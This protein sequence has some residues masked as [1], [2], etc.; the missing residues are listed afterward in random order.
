MV[1][2]DVKDSFMCYAGFAGCDAPRAVLSS[3]VAR[4]DMLGIMA[5]MDQK[6]SI[7]RDGGYARRRLLQWHV[8]VWFCRYSSPR[9]VVPSVPCR[10]KMLG[11]MASMHLDKDV[12]DVNEQQLRKIL[13]I[14]Q[15]H[16]GEVLLY[17]RPVPRS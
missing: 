5:G 2:L 6:D 7:P 4:P 3:V 14:G 10:P 8:R 12:D 9:D 11:I 16:H 13:S 1:A 15:R 17:R